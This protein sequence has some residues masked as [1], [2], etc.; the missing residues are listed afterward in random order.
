MITFKYV[1]TYK[2]VLNVENAMSKTEFRGIT[3]PE[4]LYLQLENYVEQ[5]NGYYVSIT[6]VVREAL[7]NYLKKAQ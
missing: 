2:G 6:E 3:L 1:S 5:S 7:R 4:G